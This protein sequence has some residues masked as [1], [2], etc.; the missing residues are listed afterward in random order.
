MLFNIPRTPSVSSEQPTA[1]APSSTV[2]R[3]LLGELLLCEIEA[4]SSGSKG[5]AFSLAFREQM[6][7]SQKVREASAEVQGSADEA[8]VGAEQK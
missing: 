1:T 2:R 6:T 3:S 7:V 8:E 5:L 4:V